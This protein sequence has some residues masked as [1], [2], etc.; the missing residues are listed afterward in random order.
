MEYNRLLL[1]FEF[2]QTELYLMLARHD[3]T[4]S[5]IYISTKSELNST[6]KSLENALKG[7]V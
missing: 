5:I 4:N 1:H 7:A 2:L 3:S 6:I